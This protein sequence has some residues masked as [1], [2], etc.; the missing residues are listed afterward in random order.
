M[1]VVWTIIDAPV[2]NDST[3]M[4][5]TATGA[6]ARCG[7]LGAGNKGAV[8]CSM[9]LFSGINLSIVNVHLASGDGQS[10]AEARQ[11][12]MER[13]VRD[14]RFQDPNRRSNCFEHDVTIFAGDFNSRL[15]ASSTTAS[16]KPPEEAAAEAK[17][18]VLSAV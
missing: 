2:A 11:H 8:G 15:R 6:K 4:S 7:T 3:P 14:L 9:G 16:D 12:D 1:G 13:I 17:Q 5:H 18:Q 10:C